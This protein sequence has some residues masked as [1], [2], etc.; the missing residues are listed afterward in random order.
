MR[1][2]DGP[3]AVLVHRLLQVVENDQSESYAKIILSAA[4]LVKKMGW[5]APIV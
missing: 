4:R 3:R 1:P 2:G 5:L